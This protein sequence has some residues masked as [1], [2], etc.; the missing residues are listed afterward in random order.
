MRLFL[1]LFL[2]GVFPA[3]SQL[4]TPTGVTAVANGSTSIVV[5]WGDVPNATGY[6]VIREGA[7][8]NPVG[9]PVGSTFTNTGLTPGTSYTY[10]VQAVG[11][12]GSSS[13]LSDPV[14]TSTLNSPGAPTNLRATVTAANTV[15]LSWSAV[16]GA[17]GYTVYR[18]D[19]DIDDTTAAAYTDEDVEVST[20]YRYVVTATSTG[21]ESSD[22]NL[23]TVTTRGDGSQREAVWTREFERADGNFDSIVEF[24]EYLV[25]FPNTLSEVIMYHRFSS[26]DDDESG[27]L[28]V[29]EYIA[30]FAG[31][32]VKRPSKA[33]TFFI[34]DELSDIGDADGYLDPLEFALTLNRGTK[35]A[36]ITKKFDKLDKN[37]SGLLSEV[38]F[39]IRG[40]A[41][42]EAPEI[43][44]DLTASGAPGVAFTYQI[45]ATKDP[46]SYG[47][48][49]LP[50]GLTLN[51]TTGIISGIPTTAGVYTVTISATDGS[52]TDSATLTIRI[53]VPA[54]TSDLTATGTTLAA[55][56]YQIVASQSPTSYGATGLPTGLAINTSTGEITGT[57]SAAGTSNVTISATNLIGTGSATLVI[58]ITASPTITSALTKSGIT[59]TAFSYQIAAT[60]TPT[61]Y[62]A[63]GLP[64]GLVI[65]P[66]TGAITGTPTAAGPFNVTIS[67][68]NATGTGSATLVI[69]ITAPVPA[70]TSSLTA[71]GTTLASFNYQIVATQSPTGYGATG[72]PGGVTVNP[73]T[74]AITGTPT[75]TGVFNAT[76]SATNSGGTGSATLVITIS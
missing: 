46:T 35:D 39:G 7:T 73:S 11:A 42:E 63:T 54:I 68:T 57:A 47:A 44:S 45:E 37:D 21:G 67:A 29:D 27:D 13:S 19:V 50:S 65:T 51:A 2:S 34:A 15:V 23:V 3:L 4:A 58:T 61:S 52:G 75:A 24:D 32:T 25:A 14:T 40:G 38:E 56:S 49:P 33:Q 31:K 5:D 69:T 30:H 41:G 64:A 12:L 60:Q 36:V 62:D 53:G 28:T 70:I 22:S 16:S 17:T 26:S 48:T 76:I 74:G 1:L 43:T 72:L 8:S 18:N 66:S 20:T 6:V 10:R 9:S 55:F 71:S 59:G